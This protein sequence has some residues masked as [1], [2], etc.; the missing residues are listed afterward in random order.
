MSTALIAAAAP[1][2]SIVIP[3][4]NS[5][6]QLRECLE[7]LQESPFLDFEVIVVDD[8]STDGTAD[9]ARQMQATVL[10][11]ATNAGPAAAR[12][13]GAQAARG[14]ILMFLDADVLV[15]PD[16]L[17]R[18]AKAFSDP[19]IDAV[20]GSYDAQPR[21]ANVIS[22]YR[23]L[24]HHFTHQVSARDAGTFWAGCGAVR[25]SVFESHGGF[26]A[27][28][29][30][31]S[32]EDIEFGVRLRRAGRR[33]LLDGRIQVTHLKRWRFWGM[34]KTDYRDRALP[35]T[36]LILRE[37]SMP[38]DLNLG[39]SQR[40][41]ALVSLAWVGSFVLAAWH[42]HALAC[43]LPVLFLLAVVL[44]DHLPVARQASPA[45]RLTALA[46]VL[47]G[48]VATGCLLRWWML[49]PIGLALCLVALNLRFYLFLIRAR[50]PLFAALAFPLHAF[51]Y[52]YSS[53]AFAQGLLRHRATKG[54]GLP[55][56]Q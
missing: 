30:R 18:V 11:L 29:G 23:N 37:Q 20:F 9:V 36:E 40:L 38:N 34:L 26:D 39:I 24:L 14:D 12:N 4:R 56:R 41:S 51:Y 27:G 35:W 53:I 15:H 48:A 45:W 1:A 2:V 6:V 43:L 3:V 32:I 31:P 44:I 10:S 22:Q 28:Y 46:F 25:R 8:A 16:T 47:A 13:R 21:A 7:R 55:S 50:D 33:I 17:Q 49:V 54:S 5:P 52:L 19:A 42:V